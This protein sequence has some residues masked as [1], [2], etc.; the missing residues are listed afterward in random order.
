MQV[1]KQ[2][3]LEIAGKKVRGI[4]KMSNRKKKR[5]RVSDREQI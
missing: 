5:K 4:E 3:K 1:D 2:I